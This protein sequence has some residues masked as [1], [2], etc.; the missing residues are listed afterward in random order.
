ML[1]GVCDQEMA[2]SRDTTGATWSAP[3]SIS[4][5]PCTSTLDFYLQK[6]APQLGLRLESYKI[7]DGIAQMPLRR[8]CPLDYIMPDE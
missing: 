5:K 4:W 3:V 7:L 2:G 1:V 8:I 6:H